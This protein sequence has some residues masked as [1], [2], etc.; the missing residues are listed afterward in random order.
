MFIQSARSVSRSLPFV[1]RVFR[2]KSVIA[3]WSHVDLLH[4]TRSHMTGHMTERLWKPEFDRLM[5][6]N[7][8]SAGPPRVYL[9]FDEMGKTG[10]S[11][12]GAD[13]T[14]HSPD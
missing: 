6:W 10:G 7:F 8:R 5:K 4:R 9:C 1:H 12:R 11:L 3:A 2:E 14:D 13:M